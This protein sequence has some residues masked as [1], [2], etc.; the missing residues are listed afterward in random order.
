MKII[1]TIIII[2]VLAGFGFFIFNQEDHLEED[3][4]FE[5]IAKDWI[6]ENSKTFTQRGGHDLVHKETVILEDGT[7]EVT[8]TFNSSVAGYGEVE[9]DEVSAT[10]ITPHTIKLKIKNGKVI[11]AVIDDIF[12]EKELQDEEVKEESEEPVKE[13]KEVTINIYF[14]IIRDEVEEVD[15]VKRVYFLEDTSLLPEIAILALLDGPTSEEK[16][17]GYF[18]AI[19]PETTLNFINIENRTAFVDFN[20]EIDASGSAT[21]LMIRDQIKKTLS[22]FENIDNVVISIE[23]ETEDIL[24]P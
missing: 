3:F 9:E 19:N 11:S 2:L 10:V 21:V 1:V 22:Q 16:T 18:T 24:E 23:T 20:Q 4:S 5:E 14:G 13:E 15:S 7:A 8:F 6:E 17:E 12:Q